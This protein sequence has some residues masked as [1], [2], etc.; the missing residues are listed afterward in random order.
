MYAR[1]R[2]HLAMRGAPEGAPQHA[3]THTGPVK[4]PHRRRRAWQSCSVAAS[5]PQAHV[6]RLP[7]A[8]SSLVGTRLPVVQRL[9][10]TG[11]PWALAPGGHT[12][13]SRHTAEGWA[14]RGA[15]P[16]ASGG[17][18]RGRVTALPQC[19]QRARGA[20]LFACGRLETHSRTG[21]R[22]SRRGSRRRRSWSARC[23]CCCAACRRAGT[24]GRQSPARC[25]TLTAHAAQRVSG[26]APPQA[27]RNAPVRTSALVQH[28]RHSAV[29]HRSAAAR[30]A[31][32]ANRKASCP[33][34]CAAA[35]P[36]RHCTRCVRARA[37]PAAPPKER[38]A[39]L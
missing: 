3:N 38:D 12:L 19:V 29:S 13:T 25:G 6:R 2:Q 20:R 27:A 16:R 17:R 32:R 7:C 31:L 11:S 34:V 5:P 24:S 14:R 21:G 23:R 9:A 39:R 15:G 33:P 10:A 37:A 35:P 1:L 22:P 8:S 36:R 28:A 18:G 4:A 26:R 30:M